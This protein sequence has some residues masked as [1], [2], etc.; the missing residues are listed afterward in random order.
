MTANGGGCWGFYGKAKARKTQFLKNIS[1]ITRSCF[2]SQFDCHI[3]LV[4]ILIPNCS[5]RQVQADSV[6]KRLL[7]RFQKVG[8][9]FFDEIS[10]LIEILFTHLSWIGNI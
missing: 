4:E 8:N 1:E 3:E 9:F 7:K 2:E 5:L 10:Y 6:L